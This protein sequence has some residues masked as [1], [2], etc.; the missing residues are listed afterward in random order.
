MTAST[1]VRANA[2][3]INTSRNAASI[4]SALSTLTFSV[5]P[6]GKL[7]FMRSTSARTPRAISSVLPFDCA[8][9]CIMRPG[10]PFSR[11]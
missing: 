1:D 2:T 7:S 9:T 6:A 5:V 4:G 10:S 8:C 11:L 3:A